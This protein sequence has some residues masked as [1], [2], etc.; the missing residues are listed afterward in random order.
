[1]LSL[2][3]QP[4][5]NPLL[6]GIG[7]RYTQQCVCPSLES[8][9]Q[10]GPALAT[11]IGGGAHG[12][13]CLEHEPNLSQK[14]ALWNLYAGLG[15][16]FKVVS[17]ALVLATPDGVVGRQTV[18]D[19]RAA[20]RL[21]QHLAHYL[22]SSAFLYQVEGLCGGGEHPQPPSRTAYPPTGLVGVDRRARPDTGLQ[23]L[24]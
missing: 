4:V 21:T 11:D 10:L 5:G 8:G 9:S 20:E 15:N 19:Q 6:P 23:L 12:H 18:A 13:R 14:L 17:I 7:I 16:G 2:L 22:L 24:V 3:A 1:M